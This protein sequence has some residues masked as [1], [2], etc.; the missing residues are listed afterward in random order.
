MLLG[1][2]RAGT[3]AYHPRYEARRVPSRGW[4]VPYRGAVTHHADAP[5][6]AASPH[7]ERLLGGLASALR[8]QDYH[9]ITIADIVRHARVSKRTFYEQFGG[10]D[11]CFV[12]LLRHTVSSTV[13]AIEA[14]V[15]PAD[16]WPQQA[17]QAVEALVASVEAEPEV[18]LTWLRAAP[19]T[20]AEGRALARDGMASFVA[21]IQALART[22]S[23]RAAGVSPPSRQLAI[24]LV[25]GLRELI[26]TTL[27]EGGD[28]RGIVDV[29]TDATM[30]LLGP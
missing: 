9:A 6:P 29:A 26:D 16:D 25:G 17:R 19:S 22:P 5:D 18:H 30:L 20:G 12:A 3:S 1:S 4:P 24:V 23:L 28:L 8:E 27:E 7:R 10:K 13:T 14:A 21:L 15:D 11:E 2:F